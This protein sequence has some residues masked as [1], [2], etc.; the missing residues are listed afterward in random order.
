MARVRAQGPL[1]LDV[2]VVDLH[3]CA[4]C[5]GLYEAGMRTCPTCGRWLGRGNLVAWCALVVLGSML[6][7]LAFF[8]PWL[9]GVDVGHERALSGYDLAQIAQHLAATSARPTGAA[10]IALYL[11]PLASL[12]MLAVVAAAPP[13]GLRWAA[14]GRLLVGLG[15]IPCLLALLA[16]LFAL[17][18][19]GGARAASVPH[20]GLIGTGVGSMLA[21]AGG[22]ALG[23]P[24][25]RA[26]SVRAL[27]RFS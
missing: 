4:R 17:G 8:L 9:N 13:L 23:G 22:I 7:T 2:P 5:G 16:T 26:W 1:A 11:A 15:A 25:G 24:G 19:L 21:I 12:T 27:R 14:V 20:I 6:T 10:S 18:L 3:V